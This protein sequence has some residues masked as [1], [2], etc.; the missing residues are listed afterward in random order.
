MERR[1]ATGVR[2]R[3]GVRA[4]GWR[5][6]S[7]GHSRREHKE[8]NMSAHHLRGALQSGREGLRPSAASADVGRKSLTSSKTTS[9]DG[10]DDDGRVGLRL[11]NSTPR[12]KES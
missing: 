5:V 2:S 7:T 11:P 1:R 8:H 3:G 4:G 6:W 12:R 10:A 9:G